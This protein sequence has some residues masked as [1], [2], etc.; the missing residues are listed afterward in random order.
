MKVLKK[1]K[2]DIEVCKKVDQAEYL[3]YEEEDV[4]FIITDSSMVNKS[5]K[6]ISVEVDAN[7]QATSPAGFNKT[8]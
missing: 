5:N 8:Q 2:T 6:L 4:E 3:K 7:S 1:T